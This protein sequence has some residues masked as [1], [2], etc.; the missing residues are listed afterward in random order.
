MQPITRIALKSAIQ[1]QFQ[2]EDNELAAEPLP[3][4]DVPRLILFYEAS[5]GG[6]G[7]LRRHGNNPKAELGKA[8]GKDRVEGPAFLMRR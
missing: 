3:S 6:A 4:P 5:E 7:V 1:V 8:L 2:L